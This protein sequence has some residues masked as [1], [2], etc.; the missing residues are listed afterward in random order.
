[1]EAINAAE[2][3]KYF[4]CVKWGKNLKF[5]KFSQLFRELSENLAK[6]LESMESHID[7]ALA[8]MTIVFDVDRYSLVNSAYQML[9]KLQVYI[10]MLRP[11]AKSRKCVSPVI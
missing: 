8:A 3:Y 11:V 9:G 10:F 4:F 1:M 7:D 2:R 6:T 5:K